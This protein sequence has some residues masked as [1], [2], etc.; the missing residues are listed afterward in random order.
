[1][2]WCEPI[3]DTEHRQSGQAGEPRGQPAMGARRAQGVAAAVD[4][5]DCGIGLIARH[6]D[7]VDPLTRRRGG[8]LTSW[9]RR[10]R[11]ERLQATA[12][13]CP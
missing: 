10:E 5:K 7:A 3:V 11:R 9:C 8:R 12:R 4:E 2:A 6:P 1:M 13:R